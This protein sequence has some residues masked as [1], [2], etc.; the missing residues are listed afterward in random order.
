MNNNNYLEGQLFS[1]QQSHSTWRTDLKNDPKCVHLPRYCMGIKSSVGRRRI[2]AAHI[3]SI[4]SDIFQ[5][6]RHYRDWCWRLLLVYASIWYLVGWWMGSRAVVVKLEVGKLW[7]LWSDRPRRDVMRCDATQRSTKC[8]DC[9]AG[10]AIFHYII[11]KSH[12]KSINDSQLMC[13]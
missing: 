9:Q 2:R 5:D 11:N 6:L 1:V 7:I 3:D 10:L 13:L 12:I 8:C 4:D